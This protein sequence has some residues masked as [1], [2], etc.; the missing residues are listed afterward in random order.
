MTPSESPPFST[1]LYTY[2]LRFQRDHAI[3]T[4]NTTSSNGGVFA[5]DRLLV[6][7]VES[8]TVTS[9]LIAA[10]FRER[11]GTIDAAGRDDEVM[12]VELDEQLGDGA[13]PHVRDHGVQDEPVPG[14]HAAEEAGHD[15]GVGGV[16][17]VPAVQTDDAKGDLQV[18]L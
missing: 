14:G 9:T 18:Y 13:V 2:S 15:V 11:G 5:G 1:R 16:E 7:V 17:T 10:V 3:Y 12:T 4:S 6:L 8:N